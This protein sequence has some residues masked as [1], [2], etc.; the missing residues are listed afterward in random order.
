MATHR[1]A[2]LLSWFS[3]GGRIS[4]GLTPR[5][6]FLDTIGLAG[7]E[8]TVTVELNDDNQHTAAGSCVF[9]VS[10]PPKN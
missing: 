5:S 1:R 9:N 4:E 2:V 3:T 10:P 7:K 8:V 6:I